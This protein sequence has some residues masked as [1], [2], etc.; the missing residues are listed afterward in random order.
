MATILSPSHCFG[1]FI[2]KE[3]KYI[4]INAVINTTSNPLRPIFLISY[5]PRHTPII[6]CTVLKRQFSFSTSKT[7]NRVQPLTHS[8]HKVL[9]SSRKVFKSKTVGIYI[10]KE[11]SP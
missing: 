3:N 4:Y 5:S 6:H 2:I 10:S 11:P 9:T 1:I 8:L 7:E